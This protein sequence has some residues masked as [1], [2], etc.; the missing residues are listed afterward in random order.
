M[1]RD[2]ADAA[3]IARLSPTELRVAL[4]LL[5]R[6]HRPSAKRISEAAGLT[7]GKRSGQRARDRV[8]RLLPP[9]WVTPSQRRDPSA[10]A[11]IPAIGARS[12]SPPADTP[13]CHPVT[14]THT[15]TSA[16][17]ASDTSLRETNAGLQ[18]A[19]K[20]LS[21]RGIAGSN[22]RALAA[23]WAN[24]IDH[25]TFLLDDAAPRAKGPGLFVRILESEEPNPDFSQPQT[26]M[27]SRDPRVV[28]RANELVHE[29][30][31]LDEDGR[32]ALAKKHVEFFGHHTT[33]RN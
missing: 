22:Q 4:F 16:P 8:T 2:A 11:A 3:I 18:Q 6:S 17:D 12:A 30:P 7:G 26:P 27:R 20:V 23:R 1:L 5:T 31:D 10:D 15:R 25:L 29:R 32:W 14:A 13:A 28:V 33:H 9:D 21:D 19:R 24:A